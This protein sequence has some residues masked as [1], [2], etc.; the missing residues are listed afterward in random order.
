MLTTAPDSR[1][2]VVVGVL[3][4]SKDRLLVQRRQPGTPRAGQWEFPGGKLEHGEQPLGALQRELEEELGVTN[5]VAEPLVQVAHDYEHA[6]VWLDVYVVS[7]Y[8]GRAVNREGQV[9]A[10]ATVEDISEMD[11]LPAVHPILEAYRSR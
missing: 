4:D 7:R 2:Y 3:Q 6:R 9:M 8:Q 10:W 11:I 5:V 1:L